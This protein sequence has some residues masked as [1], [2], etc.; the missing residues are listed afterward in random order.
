MSGEST[1]ALVPEPEDETGASPSLRG[2]GK[3]DKLAQ[4]ISNVAKPD[5]GSTGELKILGSKQ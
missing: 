2:G 3:R 1:E 5:L 4:W